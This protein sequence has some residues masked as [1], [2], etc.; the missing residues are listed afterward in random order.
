LTAASTVLTGCGPRW[1]VHT[2]A[3]PD[4]FL[5][6]KAFAVLPVDFTGLQIGEKSEQEYLAG[7]NPDQQ[8]SFKADKAALNGE[9]LREL[10]DH[11]DKIGVR[12]VPATG[13]DSA[14]FLIKPYVAWIEP[15]Y[16]AVVSARPSEV[17][18]L[19]RI[20]SPDGRVLDEIAVKSNSSGYASG[21]RL[22]N[23]GNALGRITAAY[24]K[25]RVAPGQ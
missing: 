8:E 10:S 22:R 20:T 19:V 2:Q 15:G 5:N 1:I 4:P 16:Y 11:A 3:A 18:M 7:K 13:P 21:Q 12:V 23:D 17:R 6:Q 14:P 25:T 24:L 9:Y